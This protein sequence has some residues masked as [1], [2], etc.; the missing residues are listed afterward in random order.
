MARM[1]HVLLLDRALAAVV[2]VGGARAA[3][4][5]AAALERAKV[6]LVADAHEGRGPDVGVADGA[7]A[8]AAV[9]Q[10]ADGCLLLLLL[11]EGRGLV[12]KGGI[13]GRGALA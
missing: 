4:H 5:H 9:A 6:A 10:A 13:G 1:T 8:V 12:L 3:A 11:V 7:L 2:G